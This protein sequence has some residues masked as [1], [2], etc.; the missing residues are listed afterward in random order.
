MFN[1]SGEEGANWRRCFK[2]KML[3]EF[4]ESVTFRKIALR[5]NPVIEKSLTF[6]DH[7]QCH[8]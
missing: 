8:L 1:I 6:D 5:I 3:I 4:M 7:A 2:K